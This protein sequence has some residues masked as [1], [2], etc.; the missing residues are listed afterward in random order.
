MTMTLCVS[1]SGIYGYRRKSLPKYVISS[2]DLDPV[3]LIL[4]L[5][6]DMVNIYLCT[7]NETLALAAQKLQSEQTHI[8]R[9]T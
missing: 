3:T 5:G 7:E 6:L 9:Q 4:K 2:F 1:F 8:H